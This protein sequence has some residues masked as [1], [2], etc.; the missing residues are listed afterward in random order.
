MTIHVWFDASETT[1]NLKEVRE[2][3]TLREAS[4]TCKSVVKPNDAHKLFGEVFSPL[5]AAKLTLPTF[6]LLRELC[7]LY[8][9]CK[10]AKDNTSP[11][12]ARDDENLFKAATDKLSSIA[13]LNRDKGSIA[14]YIGN[15]FGPREGNPALK[16][17]YESHGNVLVWRVPCDI[18]FGAPSRH[19]ANGHV[20]QP[21][22]VVDNG[23]G[24]SKLRTFQE[25]TGVSRGAFFSKEIA[26]PIHNF[27]FDIYKAIA[28]EA[29]DVSDGGHGHVSMC[30][31]VDSVMQE[32]T[33]MPSH[34]EATVQWFVTNINPR[35]L[36][37]RAAVTFRLWVDE[38]VAAR[39]EAIL[40]KTVLLVK[41]F[42]A[43]DWRIL[44]PG[45][46]HRWVGTVI[47][48]R[49]APDSDPTQ[50]DCFHSPWNVKDATWMKGRVSAAY[51]YFTFS[52]DPSELRGEHP[53][54]ADTVCAME[55]DLATFLKNSWSLEEFPRRSSTPPSPPPPTSSNR[56]TPRGAEIPKKSP[57]KKQASPPR[58]KKR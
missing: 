11:G 26:S 54:Y 25:L 2:G 29:V 30:W 35:P 42:A 46:A 55:D 51:L 1:L 45:N 27:A 8:N 10:E 50:R 7:Q 36:K 58:R 57:T 15:R 19:A 53:W 31:I 49:K 41:E 21:V 14:K 44:K 12:A 37:E 4:Y 39:N 33:Y 52:G 38:D 40:Q 47:S 34:L 22:P 32:L 48:Y 16:I 17:W 5:K 3:I 18:V 28:Q 13:H 24:G 56:Q 23:D 20:S 6:E 9:Q 43:V